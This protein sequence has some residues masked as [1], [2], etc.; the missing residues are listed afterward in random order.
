MLIIEGGWM[1]IIEG[2]WVSCYGGWIVLSV[3]C[4]GGWVREGRSATVSYL[5]WLIYNVIINV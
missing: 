3:V 1:L 2:G 5:Y 4:E